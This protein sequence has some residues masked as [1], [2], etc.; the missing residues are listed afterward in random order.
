M[1]CSNF[2]CRIYV[3]KTPEQYSLNHH[4]SQRVKE[5]A[6][7]AIYSSICLD[8]GQVYD[9]DGLKENYIMW[10]TP[11][12]EGDRRK[13]VKE[14]RKSI[15]VAWI[16][17]NSELNNSASPRTTIS[18]DFISFCA[19]SYPKSLLAVISFTKGPAL[20]PTLYKFIVLGSLGLYSNNFGFGLK[21]VSLQLAT[22]VGRACTPV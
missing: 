2:F 20:S 8:D 19:C 5:D 22:F 18:S 17:R 12:R 13:R 21:I 6:W 15:I 7:Q 11:H 9:Q 4:C 16:F 3:E 10:R 1:H 14:K